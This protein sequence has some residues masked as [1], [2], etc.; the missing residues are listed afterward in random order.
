MKRMKARFTALSFGALILLGGNGAA[1]EWT[2]WRGPARDGVARSFAAPKTWPQTLKRKW[3]VAVGSGYSSPVV[4]GGRVFLHTRQDEQEIVSAFD[5]ATGRAVWTQAYAAAFDKNQYA[6]KMGKG[7]NSTPVL[8]D[9][10]L[11]AFGVNAV[12]S[13]FDARTGALFWRKDFG[14]P[15]TSKLLC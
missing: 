3:K 9:G 13:S 2:Q 5:L 6:V 15:D 1:Q 4:G 12:L 8:Y 7:P 14:R 11:Y 10:K